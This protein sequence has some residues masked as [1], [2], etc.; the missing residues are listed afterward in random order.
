MTSPDILRSIG[1]ELNKNG[2][3]EFNL[4]QF[5]RALQLYKEAIQ[6]SEALNEN[7]ITEDDWRARAKYQDNAGLTCNT[8]LQRR[9]W[10]E[11]A[12]ESL[13]HIK[14]FTDRDWY[15]QA[16]YQNNIGVIS[17]REHQL[18]WF[19]KALTS[20][21][22]IK[23]FTDEYWRYHAAFNDN[24]GLSCLDESQQLVFHQKALGSLA[25]IQIVTDHDWRERA[26]YQNN[27]GI[28]CEVITQKKEW[29]I[30]ALDSLTY[31]HNF[32]DGDWF[33][34]SMYQFNLGLEQ[35]GDHQL[36]WHKKA[37]ASLMHIPEKNFTPEHW[38]TVALYRNTMGDVYQESNQWKKARNYCF[39]S[40]DALAHIV[41][42][43][44]ADY[45]LIAS[46][47]AQLHDL[48]LDNTL[49][50]KLYYFAF[51]TFDVAQS[52]AYK[53]NFLQL[54]LSIFHSFNHPKILQLA[55]IQL[56]ELMQM[57][58]AQSNFPNKSAQEWLANEAQLLQFKN[59]LKQ[60]KEIYQPLSL[61]NAIDHTPT[62]SVAVAHKLSSQEEMINELKNEITFLKEANQQFREVLQQHSLFYQN[63][64]SFFLSHQ[65][66]KQT[67][68]IENREQN[69]NAYVKS[70]EHSSP[71]NFKGL[72]RSIRRHI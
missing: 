70:L 5:D 22:N 52:I 72:L 3:D 44:L 35:E 66:N 33:N 15:T 17:D 27:A 8:A 7:D 38:R 24:A 6:A 26:K 71:S 20:L 56:M 29:Y 43:D 37:L 50:E 10:H 41:Q 31:I 28:S 4:K 40:L 14:I 30:K 11:I 25:H 12:L 55:F 68:P 45:E 61:L 58:I 65:N 48:S 34:Q 32:N 60:A 49:E 36:T 57:N 18:T 42:H 16:L 69:K 59:M 2:D 67:V 9:L 53:E 39:A 1:E 62:F 54:H 46:N 13:S 64:S 63:H 51:L 23:I 19:E 47:Y 21:E